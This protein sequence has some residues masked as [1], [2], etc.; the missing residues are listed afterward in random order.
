MESDS[1]FNMLRPEAVES[2]YLLY[3]RTG[4]Q[5]YRDMG[6]AI[7]EAFENHCRVESGGYSGEEGRGDSAFWFLIERFLVV[8]PSTAV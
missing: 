8:L 6:W 4:E 3:R 5:R 7:F 2:L 1:P